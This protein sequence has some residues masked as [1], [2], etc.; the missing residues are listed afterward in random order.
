MKIKTEINQKKNVRVHIVSGQFDYG[1]ARMYEQELENQ[2]PRK[3]R[4]FK[5]IKKAVRWIDQGI[6]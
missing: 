4:V 5:D 3:I 1:L 2:S 6:H